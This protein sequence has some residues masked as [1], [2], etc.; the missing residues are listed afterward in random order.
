M[1][2]STSSSVQK[3]VRKLRKL[4]VNQSEGWLAAGTGRPTGQKPPP[5][6]RQGLVWSSPKRLAFDDVHDLARLR[7]D[8]HI[9]AAHEDHLIATPLRVDL[10]DAG[11]QRVEVYGCRDRGADRDVEVD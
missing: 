7:P 6:S 10:D 3:P 4:L 9:L 11:R 8:D 1:G 5:I 2:S